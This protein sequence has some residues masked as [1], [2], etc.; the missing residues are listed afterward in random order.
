MLIA[1]SAGKSWSEMD[2]VANLAGVWKVFKF[3]TFSREAS[4]AM[5]SNPI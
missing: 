5:I 4:R 1:S 2:G 3:I